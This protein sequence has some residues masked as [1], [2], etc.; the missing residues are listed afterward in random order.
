MLKARKNGVSDNDYNLDLAHQ[1]ILRSVTLG[2]ESRTVCSNN[3][4]WVK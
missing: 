2:Q 4:K 3:T 1:R